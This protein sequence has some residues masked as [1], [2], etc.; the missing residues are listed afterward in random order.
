M[1]AAGCRNE[2]AQQEKAEDYG[3]ATYAW[4][5]GL[6][7]VSDSAGALNGLVFSV[8]AVAAVTGAIF[9]LRTFTPVLSLGVLYVFAVL[10][11]AI[12]WGLAYAVLVSIASMLAFNFFFLPPV[13]T[14]ALSDSENWF[15]LAVY[16]VTAVVVSELAARARRRAF[17]AEEREREAA[18][19]AEKTVEAEA[20][21]RSDEA[22]T[23]LLRA[24]SHDLRSPLTAIKAATEGLESTA[25]NLGSADRA[26]L[27]TA[28]RLEAERLDRLVANLLD[29]SR[30]EVGAV[31]V[32]PE[33]WSVD[34][35]VGRALDAL[36]LEATR[37]TVSLPDQMP[38]VEADAGQIERALVNLLENALKFSLPDARVSVS[39][40]VQGSEVI[41]AVRDQGVG[42][43]PED[44]RTIF[45]PFQRGASGSGR[46]GSGLGLAI[47]RGFVQANRGR[48]W[49]ESDGRGA[50]FYLAL[51]MVEAAVEIP[52]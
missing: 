4:D 26:E 3:L 33:L 30:L 49:A 47:V 20:L 46:P 25:F 31:N 6:R 27:L 7:R 23:A 52:T 13:H 16:L 35:L 12:G 1:L 21:R 39:V 38:V 34:E 42:L 8:L 22:K 32:N 37:V 24:V 2:E 9:G 44:L 11:V 19:L 51:P 29:L 18:E 45:E 41:I 50:A 15:A 40:D 17:E 28:I 36:G 10:P 14:L 5:M 43:A 48:V